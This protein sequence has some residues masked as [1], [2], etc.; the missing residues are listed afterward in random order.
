M[1]GNL[2]FLDFEFPSNTES[3]CWKEIHVVR[4][5]S[6]KNEKSE[7]GKKFQAG[8]FEIKSGINEVGKFELKLKNF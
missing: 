5:D 4:N 1:K 2:H 8:K 6:L 3:C 7:A